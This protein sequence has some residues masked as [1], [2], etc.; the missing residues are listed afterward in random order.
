MREQQ[1][2]S[3]LVRQTPQQGSGERLKQ[4]GL[5]GV[6]DGER[7]EQGRGRTGRGKS[8]TMRISTHGRRVNRDRR[9][10]AVPRKTGLE[11]PYRVMALGGEVKETL[12]SE[13]KRA[14]RAGDVVRESVENLCRD[15]VCIGNVTRPVLA[16]QSVAHAQQSQP[17]KRALRERSGKAGMG[18]IRGE[19]SDR[20]RKRAF[21]AGV[22]NSRQVIQISKVEG[23]GSGVWKERPTQESECGVRETRREGGRM[24]GWS[25]RRVRNR[26][27]YYLEGHRVNRAS[28]ARAKSSLASDVDNRRL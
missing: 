4:R 27:D 1:S 14:R 26:C 24:V 16:T 5:V 17:G 25:T 22:A 9:G 13:S 10:M 18:R 19:R 15:E 21:M 20:T 3:Q 7:R 6:D 28:K 23:R 12:A 11:V 2:V 8:V